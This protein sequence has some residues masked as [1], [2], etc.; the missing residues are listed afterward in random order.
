MFVIEGQP[1]AGVFELLRRSDCMWVV[2]SQ[3]AFAE[4]FMKRQ[5]VTN[6]MWDVLIGAYS[7]RIDLDPVAA[8]LVDNRAI[9]VEQGVEADDISG[10]DSITR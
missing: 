6:A 2:I 10:A 7:P 5:R 9:Q 3:N 1:S 8:A 4:W